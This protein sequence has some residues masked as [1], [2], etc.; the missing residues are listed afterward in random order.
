MV[1][2]N[3]I[4]P[5]NTKILTTNIHLIN[6]KLKN[7]MGKSLFE[8]SSEYARAIEELENYC[9]DNSTDEVPEEI[10]ERLVINKDELNDKLES[11]FHV[12]TD[13]EG[14]TETLS[15][16]IKSAQQKKTAVQKNIDRLKGY[17]GDALELYGEENKTGNKFYKHLLFKVTASRS[18][19]LRI[20]D[21][22]ALPER[23]K[24]LVIT[25]T[26][27]VDNKQLKA[28]LN[29]EDMPFG[30]EG[31]EIDDSTINVTFR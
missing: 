12:L 2:L 15:A 7:K 10:H 29:N 22:D 5:T 11:Y 31:A 18:N 8:I 23:Y 27:K 3:L 9:M 25:K 14:D 1:N 28:D 6:Y 17:V 19:K 21:V 4:H 24:E 13:L 16:Y 20:T 26:I 30:V